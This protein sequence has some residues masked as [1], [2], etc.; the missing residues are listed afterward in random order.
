MFPMTMQQMPANYQH[1]QGYVQ[2][3]WKPPDIPDLERLKGAVVAYGKPSP[4]V[5]QI[6]SHWATQNRVIPQDW[7]G[8]ME[9]IL[10]ASPQLLWLTWWRK[11]AKAMEQHHQI[12]GHGTASS[13]MSSEYSKGPIIRSMY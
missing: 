7:Q 12:R 6:L 3:N 5:K 13:D 10:E 11:E 1:S 8:P 2:I 9:A 4:C